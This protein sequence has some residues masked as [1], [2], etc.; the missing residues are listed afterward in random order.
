MTAAPGPSGQ[1]AVA[2]GPLARLS[3]ADQALVRAYLLHVAVEKRLAQRTVTLYTL[4]LEKLAACAV[5]ER[6]SP[7]V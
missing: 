7:G 3:D 4:D 6:P 5:S 2:P 1:G